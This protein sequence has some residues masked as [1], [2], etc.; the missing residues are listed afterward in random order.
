[1]SKILHIV[2]YLKKSLLF[3]LLGIACLLLFD[4]TFAVGEVQESLHKEIDAAIAKVKPALVRIFVVSTDYS[5]GREIKFEE[6]GSGVIISK[7]GYIITNHHVAGHATRLVCTLANKEEVD[8]EL[9]GTDPLA[10]IS[11]IK[12]KSNG[13]KEYPYAVF[14]DSSKAK[15]GDDVLAMGSPLALSQS[16]TLGIISNTEMVMPKF[17][18]PFERFKLDGEDVGSIVRWIGHDAA[19]Y[20]GNSGGPL[21]N[22]KGEIIGINEI[23][24]GLSGAI[25]GNL[26]KEVADELIKNKKVSR[27]WIGIEIQPQFKYA[28]PKN[29]ILISGTI[30]NSPGAKAGFQSG[31]VLIKLDGKEVNAR[32]DEEI[33]LFNRMVADIP[34]GKTIDAVVLRDGKEVNL[35]VTTMERAAIRPKEVELN[36]WGITVRNI[37]LLAAKE[38]KRK[39]QNGV[40]VTSIRPGGPA[41]ES[42]PIIDERDIIVKVNGE[43]I[44]NVKDLTALTE[45]VTQGKREP[46]PVIVEYDRKS[47]KY[48]TVVKVGIK[49]LEDPGLEV[50]KAWLPVAMQVITR[51]MAEQLGIP[52]QTGV[53]VTQVYPNSTAEKAG[54][55]VGDLIVG[56]DGEKIAASQPEDYEVLPTMIRQY[57]VG[58]TAGLTILRGKDQLKIP[59]ELVRAPKLEREMKKYK[60]ENF[61]FTVRDVAFLDKAEEEWKE[62]QSGVIA[63]EVKEGGWAALGHL[64]VD[65]LILEVNNQKITDVLSLEKQMK[66]ISSDKPK[67]VIIKALRGIHTVFI[68]LEPTWDKTK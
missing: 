24:L 65:D 5:E 41:G 56:L 19:I 55:K 67:S 57:K 8:A 58:A 25:P 21:V 14:G 29:G 36:Q 39:D 45:K 54:L 68:E 50:K 6:S 46:T 32:F 17:L 34:I 13:K 22:L 53:R 7:D 9:I 61:E 1:M 42:K 60:D 52:D 59:V 49:E 44:N 20:P 64:A 15:V 11:I 51:D 62:D 23:D 26:A 40:L 35:K 66:Q 37:S 3:S 27:S 30:S 31:D 12:I 43:P 16:V 63:T 18:W 38:M 4:S 33:P 47:E 48:L 2:S 10:D 28:N